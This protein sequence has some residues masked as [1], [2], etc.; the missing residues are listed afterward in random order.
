MGDIFGTGNLWGT[1]A[2]APAS[3]DIF[4]APAPAP[5]GNSGELMDPM[6]LQFTNPAL[7]TPSAAAAAP[8]PG[9]SDWLAA[10]AP[11]PSTSLDIW[12]NPAP[13][14]APNNNALS[15][16]FGLGA[17]A[18]MGQTVAPVNPKILEHI[19]KQN[20]VMK[21]E[22]NALQ[23]L[24]RL[25][26]T[27][28]VENRLPQR[29][30][31]DEGLTLEEQY[32]VIEQSYINSSAVSTDGSGVGTGGSSSLTSV[33][34]P[35][36]LGQN[37]EGAPSLRLAAATVYGGDRRKATGVLKGSP[38]QRAR[39]ERERLL[40]Q[41]PQTKAFTPT[42]TSSQNNTLPTE[43]RADDKM[44]EAMVEDG[45]SLES[46]TNFKLKD[47]TVL[48]EYQP[49]AHDATRVRN[50]GVTLLACSGDSD[51]SS[52]DSSTHSD[53]VVR[54]RLT[55]PE[56]ADGHVPVS[57]QQLLQQLRDLRLTVVKK[58][59]QPN[60]SYEGHAGGSRGAKKRIERYFFQKVEAR[61]GCAD[62]Q[63]ACGLDVEF[64]FEEHCSWDS[65]SERWVPKPKQERFLKK[66]RQDGWK[67]HGSRARR[68][69]GRGQ[70]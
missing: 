65:A 45:C 29:E 6:E 10:P 67:V 25:Q 4:G 18:P 14:P 33:H 22:I 36:R 62:L 48:V 7:S 42:K 66:L 49:V 52:G 53:F 20:T 27:N 1:P 50:V 12:G 55:T 34:T 38:A 31:E 68:I 5:V 9:P 17:P 59:R 19:T 57:G 13:A 69:F 26:R 15:D 60:P 40:R 41:S 46:D 21:Q 35:D 23:S 2:P 39:Q 51:S 32:K 43:I 56:S 11:G 47:L 64:R 63:A 54:L 61:K 3:T 37:G 24:I 44:K 8:A 30:V 58:G 28:R 16:P 70:W